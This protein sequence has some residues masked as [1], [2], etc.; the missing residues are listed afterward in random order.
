MIEE[1]VKVYAW[2]FPV[3]FTHWINVVSFLFLAV[4]GFYIGSPFIHAYS[5]N[6]Y[7][8][9]W[10]RFLHFTAAYVYLMGFI[11][12]TYWAFAGN[13][14]ASWKILFPVTGKD[15]GY[16]RKE[17]KYY[18]FLSKEPPHT[19]GHTAVSGLVY[20]VLLVVVIFQI[21]SGFAL[22]SVNHT[23]M[24]WTVMGG[25]LLGIMAL[26]TVRLFHH[27]TMYALIVY[28]MLHL[29]I[30]WYSDIS[31]KAGIMGSMF[32]GFKFIPRSESK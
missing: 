12:R 4:T 31:G 24:I 10:M 6:Q 30:G 5:S 16:I 32:N 17:L 23:G 2:E 27:L 20:L 15:W 19:I 7:I 28:A 9:G 26:P 25:W 14:Y 1:K 3:R 8:M 13:Q 18:L 22:Y 29:Y 21:V 11:I